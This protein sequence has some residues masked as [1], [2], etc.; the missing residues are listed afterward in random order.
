MALGGASGGGNA[1]GVRA[2][3]A[4]VELGVKDKITQALRGIGAKFLSF[5][6]LIATGGAAG[7]AAAA[8]GG[9]LAAAVP[10]LQE[11]AKLNAAGKA[12][13]STGAGISGLFGALKAVG[14]DFKEDLEG[15]TQFISTLDEA[16]QG[17]DGNAA[18]LFEGMTI[19]AQ[20]LMGLPIEEKFLRIHDEIRKLPQEQQ[21]VRLGLVGGT[22]SMK[23]WI[24]VLSVSNE[25]LRAQVDLHHMEQDQLDKATAANKAYQKAT[26]MIGRVWSQ[27]AIAVA[28]AI[29]QIANKTSEW[30]GPLRDMSTSTEFA[31]AG[32]GV[33]WAKIKAGAREMTTDWTLFLVDGIRSGVF[34]IQNLWNDMTAGMGKM[35][36][37]MLVNV[38]QSFRST[39]DGMIGVLGTLPGMG[40]TAT[41]IRRGLSLLDRVGP[42]RFKKQIDANA[43]AEAARLGRERDKDIAG[44]ELLRR[45]AEQKGAAEIAAAQA[46]L[47]ALRAAKAAA[48]AQGPVLEKAKKVQEKLTQTAGFFGS[49]SGF[50][51]QAFGAR[52]VSP[53]VA[54]QKKTNTI[55]ERI[56]QSIAGAQGLVF[57]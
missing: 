34:I 40:D 19:S 39:I 32:F 31:A 4:F 8:G 29:E 17:K 18:K 11:L 14:G 22:D 43:V 56:H 26:A 24:E 50:Y 12:L 35:F 53:Q 52:S 45:A 41:G 55:L 10:E 54:E 46:V 6:K 49:M 30:L 25:E 57:G 51:A 38:R 15:I 21:A 48:E 1:R 33:L 44:A 16:V 27:I 5:G 28:P 37:D 23:K 36:V 42:E 3:A 20:E 2:G 47:D 7:A 9:L 13:G